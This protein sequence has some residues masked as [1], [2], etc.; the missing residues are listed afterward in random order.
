MKPYRDYKNYVLNFSILSSL[1]L[2]VISLTILYFGKR[3]DLTRIY[4]LPLAGLM[5]LILVL[6]ISFQRKIIK[7]EV[8]ETLYE[9]PQKVPWKASQSFIMSFLSLFFLIILKLLIQKI[10][11]FLNITISDLLLLILNDIGM[12]IPILI[13]MIRKN[14]SIEFIGLDSKNALQEFRFAMLILPLTFLIGLFAGVIV[15]I[16]II[17]FIPIPSWFEEFLKAFSPSSFIDLV[18]LSLITIFFVAPCEEILFR[19]FI[20]RGLETSF[21]SMGGILL[22]SI[23]CGVL[24]FNPWQFFPAFLVGIVH[25][26]IFRKRRYRLWCPIALHA[27]YDITLFVLNY[28]S[29]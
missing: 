7:Q 4:S 17:P 20:Q 9:I 15:Q 10:I 12:I 29:S 1:I 11:T 2:L 3:E 26:Y 28:L 23:L 8:E 5:S 6:S 14:I 19:G 18:V 25:G 27:N 16:L 22:S 13:Y 21:G 24:H